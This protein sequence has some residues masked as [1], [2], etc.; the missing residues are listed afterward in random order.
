M[1]RTLGLGVPS[2]L[3]ATV[4]CASC[5]NLDVHFGP[6]QIESGLGYWKYGA[7]TKPIYSLHWIGDTVSVS[8]GYGNAD[9]FTIAVSECAGIRE[10]RARLL[11]DVEG[12][13]TALVA[14]PVT[15]PPEEILADAA[16]HKLVYH[17]QAHS[18]SLELSGFEEISLQPW[19]RAAETLR[20]V[21]RDCRDR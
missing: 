6:D 19:I 3:A 2:F 20:K 7:G 16:L 17:P 11:R 4:F 15:P 13:V 8:D 14:G 1:N 9:I 18:D 10:A 12:S 21:V 5:A